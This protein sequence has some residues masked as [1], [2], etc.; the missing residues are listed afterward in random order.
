MNSGRVVRLARRELSALTA[1]KTL[2]LALVVQL[3]VA[4]FSSF[5]VVGLAALYD[6]SS[7]AGGE[8]DLGVSG[9]AS[10]A[11]VDAAAD[12]D[13]VTIDR[14]ADREALRA[15]FNAGRVD[16]TAVARTVDAGDGTRID[17]TATV[18]ESSLRKSLVVVQLRAVLETLERRERAD[19]AV[20]LKTEPA[21]YPEPAGGTPY[22]GFA[23]TVLLPLLVLLPAF[24][25][26]S[27]AVD[28]VVEELERGT[29]ELLRV[30]PVSLGEVVAG[31]GLAMA[32]LAP[33]QIGLWIV[34][35]SANGTVVRG[36]PLLVGYALVLATLLVG[37]GIAL[38][39]VVPTR[40]RAQLC[41]SF[42]VLAAFALAGFVP[43]HPATTVARVGVGSATATTYTTLAVTVL[44][45]VAGTLAVG[46]L[47]ARIDPETL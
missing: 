33:A 15:A 7:T 17:V 39:L 45:A 28:S 35:L 2:V 30:A 34:L 3:F 19:R 21:P 9:E 14:Y 29:L 23:Y 20:A 26:G 4:A 31:K 38:A 42:G 12:S 36:W 43:E 41:Y 11:L 46:R 18:P 37:V 8:V 1:E 22:F 10:G 27:T 16:A 47:V 25:A 13:R 6:P 32:L 44:A 5:L 24:I 40:G